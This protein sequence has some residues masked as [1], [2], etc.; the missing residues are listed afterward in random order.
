MNIGINMMVVPSA[1]TGIGTYAVNLVEQLLKLDGE[2][3]YFIFITGDLPL[4]NVNSERH[5]IINVCQNKSWIRRILA[6]QFIL[7]FL[8]KKYKIDLLHSVAFSCPAIKLCKS[9]LTIHDLAYRVFP[10]TVLKSRRIYYNLMFPLYAAI[11]DKI[12]TV[13]ENT[14]KDVIRYFHIP[15]DRINTVLLGVSGQLRQEDSIDTRTVLSGLGITGEYLLYIGSLEPRKNLVRLLQAFALVREEVNIKMVIVGPKGW[16]YDD[17]FSSAAA[18][19]HKEDIIFTGRVEDADLPK[20]Y[21]QTNAFIFP[22]LYEGFGLPALDAMACGAPVI[23]SDTSSLREV[24]GDTAVYV[25]PFEVE[26]ISES[27]LML[28][29]DDRRREELKLK[30]LERSRQ[31][32]WEKTARMTLEVYKEVYNCE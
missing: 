13:S 22:S 25:D 26:S 23:A 18:T 21:S 5:H 14:K 30:G 3:R 24:C 28:L 29:K 7:P 11:S 17:I 19:K 20:L 1:R 31:F 9:V 2:N 16:M 27:I 10:E 15:E 4:E 8:V 12:I 6:E 32:S